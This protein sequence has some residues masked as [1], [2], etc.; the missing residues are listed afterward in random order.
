MYKGYICT[1]YVFGLTGLHLE[2]PRLFWERA[3][4]EIKASRAR[5]QSAGIYL[6]YSR[7]LFSARARGYRARARCAPLQ[8]A[9]P[10]VIGVRGG[11]ILN[12]QGLHL[13]RAGSLFRARRQHIQSAR[14]YLAYTWGCAPLQGAT[15]GVIG[16]RGG[17]ILDVQ[18]LHF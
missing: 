7:G 9:T 1:G 18:G 12:V 16:V 4:A 17:C 15:P 10:G 2:C 3:G 11:C 8:R 5:I 6:A 13:E 14:I